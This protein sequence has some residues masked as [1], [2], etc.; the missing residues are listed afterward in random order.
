MDDVTREIRQLKRSA[1]LWRGAGLIAIAWG[2][3]RPVGAVEPQGRPLKSVRAEALIVVDDKGRDR[4]VLGCEDD[5]PDITLFDGKGHGRIQATVS[6]GTGPFVAL[7]G[8]KSKGRLQL[9]VSP[10]GAEAAHIDTL[11]DKGNAYP[12]IGKDGRPVR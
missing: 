1:W 2:F 11:D 5:G 8:S 7:M 12:L 10:G 4:I 9:G 6:D 3:F